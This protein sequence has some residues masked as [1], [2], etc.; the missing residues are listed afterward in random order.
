M[1]TM[2]AGFLAAVA[3]GLWRGPTPA[4]PFLAMAVWFLF[5]RHDQRLGSR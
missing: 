4:L 5:L 3:Y 1:G 2:S